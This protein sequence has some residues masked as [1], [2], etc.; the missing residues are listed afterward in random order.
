MSDSLRSQGLYNLWNSPGQ[1]TGLG[2]L[3]D[4]QGIFSNPGIEPVCPLLPAWVVQSLKDWTSREAPVNFSSLNHPICGALLWRRLQSNSLESWLFPSV[5]SVTF[6][7]HPSNTEN[8]LQL[9][10]RSWYKIIQYDPPRN[11]GGQ[12]FFISRVQRERLDPRWLS[13]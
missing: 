6:S 9:A 13:W 7:S 8:T 3:S 2:S 1:N 12:G 11:T 4:L 5:W 10:W